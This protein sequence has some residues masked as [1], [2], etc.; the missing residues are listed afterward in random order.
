MGGELSKMI[1]LARMFSVIEARILMVGDR[2]PR[3]F[4]VAIYYYARAP[5]WPIH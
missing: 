4:F 1:P 3:A 2:V 5:F